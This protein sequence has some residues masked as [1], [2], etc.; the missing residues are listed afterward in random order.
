MTRLALFAIPDPLFPPFNAS[1]HTF[2][3]GPV[4]LWDSIQTVVFL[5]L[6]H[7]L[8]Y[9]N[10]ASRKSAKKRH[11]GWGRSMFSCS[12]SPTPIQH[13]YQDSL[14][15]I[16]DCHKNIDGP[17]KTLQYVITANAK[18]SSLYS[19]AWLTSSAFVQSLP[20]LPISGCFSRPLI[21][22]AVALVV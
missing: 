17:W 8:V 1:S 6:S 14:G 18:P 3:N 16:A 2:S 4:D 19:S 13:F 5:P 15:V 12:V 22:A 21:I 10:N 9:N 11:W 20:G 7:F